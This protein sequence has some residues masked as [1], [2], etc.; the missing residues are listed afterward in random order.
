M[1]LY[2][3]YYQGKTG[4]RCGAFIAVGDA[5]DDGKIVMAHNTHSDFGTGQL[6]NISM[7]V[8]PNKGHEFTMQTSQVL[9][10]VLRIGLFVVQELLVA[11]QLLVTQQ[12]RISE[13]LIF[14]DWE[15]NAIL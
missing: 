3:Q 12:K 13:A 8:T 9:W 11:K 5:T 15:P 2:Y 6:L 7:K 1:H 14:V 4:K 10:Q